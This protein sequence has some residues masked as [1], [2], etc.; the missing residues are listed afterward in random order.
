MPDPRLT[1]VAPSAYLLGGV[2]TWLDYIVPGL[3]AGGWQVTVALVDGVHSRGDAYLQRHPFRQ[4]R[5]V[6][7]PTG[8][9]EGRVRALASA[10]ADSGA[11]LVLG[12]NI[13]DTYDAVQRVRGDADQP[14]MAL[15]LHALDPSFLGDIT[16]L[17]KALDAV[18]CSNR[19]GAAAATELAGMPKER[20]FYAPSGTD[21]AGSS[22]EEQAGDEVALLF[23]GRFDEAEKR[24]MDLPP[25]LA[26]LDRLGVRFRI[27]LA[28]SGPDE[29]R[30][31]AALADFG[32]R[33]EFLGVLDPAAMAADFYRRGSVMLVT[34]PMETGPMVAWEAMAAGVNLVTSDFIGR[35]REGSLED[36]RNCLVYAV[37]DA[38]ACAHA[39]ARLADPSL[40]QRLREAALETVRNR[41]SIAASVAAWDRAL[42]ATLELPARPSVAATRA[43][44]SG[45]LDRL[46]GSALG[47]STRRLLGF[48]FRHESAGGEWPH[49]YSTEPEP[50]FRAKLQALEW[51]S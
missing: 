20:V 35:R 18:V 25:I 12:V 38:V 3:E 7:N 5:L 51:A 24:I 39:L 27:R 40:R 19:L 30:L 45:R 23:A 21:L 17:N 14:R 29:H 1:V 8:S 42:R 47:E 9:R 36:G 46:L 22:V 33:V 34:S 41:Y 32:N 11:E 10:I 13:V 16:R 2:Q 49:T 44:V 48:R 28:G 15:A 31:R 50:E 37:G 4:A 26:E 6:R 43:P